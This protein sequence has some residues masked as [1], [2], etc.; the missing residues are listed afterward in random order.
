MDGGAGQT[1][2]ETNLTLTVSFRRTTKKRPSPRPSSLWVG[3]A[4]RTESSSSP[5]TARTQH[6][7][8]RLRTA[9]KFSAT[10]DNTFK[11]AGG[12]NQALSEP[13]PWDSSTSSSSWTPIPFLSGFP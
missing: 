1:P 8:L 11:E 2:S 9:R 6:R 7:T 4:R 5:I 10:V 3:R 13:P 12:L